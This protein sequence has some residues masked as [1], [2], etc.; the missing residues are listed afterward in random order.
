MIQTIL[1]AIL[2]TSLNCGVPSPPPK[3][4]AP[5][6]FSEESVPIDQTFSWVSP[7]TFL[8]ATTLVPSKLSRDGAGTCSFLLDAD[9][10]HLATKLNELHNLAL[11]SRT[12]PPLDSQAEKWVSGLTGQARGI[13][14]FSLDGSSKDMGLGIDRFPAMSFSAGAKAD[15]SSIVLAIANVTQQLSLQANA[16]QCVRALICGSITQKGAYLRS[17]LYGSMLRLKIGDA[18]Y[19]IKAQAQSTT[20]SANL[21]FTL[22]NTNLRLDGTVVGRVK[23]DLDNKQYDVPDILVDLKAQRML[24]LLAHIANQTTQVAVIGYQAVNMESN[25]CAR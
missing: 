23:A 4:P 19:E 25:D 24:T 14:S 21:K 10:Q 2:S 17:I 18:S 22:S 1:I 7:N 12:P 9:V 11:S 3:Q 5:T 20:L 13:V 15:K 16:E 6:S 8:S